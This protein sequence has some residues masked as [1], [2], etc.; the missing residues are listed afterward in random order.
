MTLPLS[1]LP[2]QGSD[3][4]ECRHESRCLDVPMSRCRD[5]FPT[6]RSM[7]GHRATAPSG[8]PDSVRSGGGDATVSPATRLKWRLGGRSSAY[9]DTPKASGG[10]DAR[11]C[12]A[13][14][15][16]DACPHH[17]PAEVQRGVG[18]MGP[19]GPTCLTDP[20]CPTGPTCLTGPTC[21]TRPT[22][23]VRPNRRTATAAVR[24]TQ[25]PPRAPE[26]RVVR[27]GEVWWLSRGFGSEDSAESA[28]ATTRH[29]RE[30]N[31]GEAG[32]AGTGDGCRPHREVHRARTTREDARVAGCEA[33]R[34]EVGVVER[35]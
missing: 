32:E 34:D 25:P 3:S 23:P 13:R 31:R 16:L 27:G 7:P 11:G 10:P 4:N 6:G 17:A 14:R 29:A 2:I 21:P 35:Q 28:A 26:E 12:L 24:P 8:H 19:T 22:R 9:V 18:R 33:H 20:T 5:A 15:G 1:S 30:A